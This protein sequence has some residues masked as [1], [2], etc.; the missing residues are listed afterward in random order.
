MSGGSL[1]PESPKDV[2]CE[3]CG[4]FFR[5]D[6]I[7]PHEAHCERQGRPPYQEIRGRGGPPGDSPAGEGPGSTPDG[8]GPTPSEG[9]DPG[10]ESVE[11]DGGP[12]EPPTRDVVDEQ[13]NDTP[14]SAEELPE[15]YV[16]VE[17]YLETIDEELPDEVV[18][19]IEDAV[20]GYDVV[21]VEQTTSESIQAL[22][23]DEVDA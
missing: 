4:L 14:A 2:Q 6:G 10:P 5:N 18:D 19:A 21:D 22:H 7:D 17:R 3:H 11:T 8:K 12:I 9:D 15:R 23:F 20:E 1:D 13:E 16:S